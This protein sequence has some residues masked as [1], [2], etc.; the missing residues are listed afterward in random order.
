MD[1]IL[2]S[3][4]LFFVRVKRSLILTF[5]LEHVKECK[6]LKRQLKMSLDKSKNFNTIELERVYPLIF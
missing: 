4:S 1:I 3:V 6:L 2:L 5:E